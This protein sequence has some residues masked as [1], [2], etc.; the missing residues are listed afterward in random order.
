[1]TAKACAFAQFLCGENGSK[2]SITSFANAVG[3]KVL[4][5]KS[6]G[7]ANSG[8]LNDFSNIFYDSDECQEGA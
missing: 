4:A 3:Q 7:G 8:N 1:M 6:L 2:M 5:I